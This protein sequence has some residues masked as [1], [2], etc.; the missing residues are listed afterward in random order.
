MSV[1]ATY[2]CDNCG[3]VKGETNHWFAVQYLGT[4]STLLPTFK[5]LGFMDSGAD[6]QHLC[7]EACVMAKVSHCL[8]EISAAASQVEERRND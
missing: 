3:A 5:L 4:R 8:R 6:D 1:K 7:G 2:T